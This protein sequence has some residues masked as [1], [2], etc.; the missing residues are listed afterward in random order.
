MEH[1]LLEAACLPAPVEQHHATI[2]PLL[3]EPTLHWGTLLAT[4]I[5]HKVLCLLADTLATTGLADEIPSAFRRFLASVL[6]ASRH[7]T[8]VH[9]AQAAA[10]TD[11]AARQRIAFAAVKGIALES[12]LYGG[13]GAREFSDLDVLVAPDHADAFRRALRLL[14]YQPG[15]YDPATHHVVLDDPASATYTRLHDDLVTPC[16]AVDIITDLPQP[17]GVPP[18]LVPSMLDRRRSQPLP[19]HPQVDLPVLDPLDHLAV[20]LLTARRKTRTG[21]AVSLRM[22]A[23]ALRLTSANPQI[24]RATRLLAGG[25]VSGLDDLWDPCRAAG[26]W[27]PTAGG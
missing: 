27:A 3:T 15:H 17:A 23:D 16:T 19:G 24:T 6:R 1:L 14:G 13:R 18:D 11:A 5:E 10:L 9:R 22:R 2:R 12:Q 20:V 26:R 25:D 4:A 8:A 21:R 7:K